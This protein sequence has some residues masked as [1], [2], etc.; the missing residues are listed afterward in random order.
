MSG[1]HPLKIVIVGG[2][3]GGMSAATRARRLSE[4]SQITV[5]EAGNFVS[6][7]NCGLPYALGGIITDDKALTI[8]T[9]QSLKDRFN[10]DTYTNSE[11]VD[12]DRANKLVKVK[13]EDRDEL[14][15][16]GYDKLILAQGVERCAAQ[17]FA[18]SPLR[19]APVPASDAVPAWRAPGAHWL[20]RAAPWPG[21]A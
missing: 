15:E 14:E 18:A 21:Q 11:V 12:I 9:P 10:I 16:F 13:M 1:S 20:S 5:L 17:R 8:Q 2:N 19:Y 7:A 4:E 6:F 3:A